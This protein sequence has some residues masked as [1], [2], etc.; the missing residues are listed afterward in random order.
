MLLAIAIV[1]AVVLVIWRASDP[2]E[3]EG[4]QALKEPAAPAPVAASPEIAKPGAPSDGNASVPFTSRRAPDLSGHSVLAGAE[5]LDQGWLDEPSVH[6]RPRYA[7]LIRAREGALLRLVSHHVA[8]SSGGWVA[9]ATDVMRADAVLVAVPRGADATVVARRIQAEGY[10]TGPVQAQEAVVT[11]WVRDVALDA[12]PATID[13]LAAKLPDLLVEPDFVRFGAQVRPDDYDATRLWGLEQ[14]EAPGAWTVTT[15]ASDVV[16]A[17]I[18]S[19][20]TVAH[21]DL[22]PNLWVNPTETPGNGRDDDGNG[23]IDDVHGWNFA[24][25]NATLTDS[26]GHG[27]HVAG[28]IGAVGGNGTGVVGVNWNA[29]I[30]TLRA[31]TDTFL[32]ST[33]LNALRYATA[34]R[35]RGVRVVA[36]NMSLGGTGASLAFRQEIAAARDAGILVVAA[37]GNLSDDLPTADND[38]VA[39]YPASY[40]VD[41]ILAVAST[42]HADALS[43]FSHYGAVSVDLAA[44]GTA[45]F[46]TLTAGGYG[47]SN[48]TSMAAPHVAGAVA[49]VAAAEPSL[50]AAELRDRIVSTVDPVPALAGRVVTGGRLNVRRA[51]APALIRPRVVIGRAGRAVEVAALDRPGLTL[52]LQAMLQADKGVIPT[53]NLAW[54]M[55]DG[56]APVVF[57]STTSADTTALFPGEGRYRLRVTARAGGLQ[58]RDELVV[59]VGADRAVATAGL[60]GWWRFDDAGATTADSSGNGRTGTVTSATRTSTAVFGTA[61]QLDGATSRIGFAAPA[62]SRVTIA[63]WAR[64]TSRNAATIF[65]RIVHMREG[66][67]FG[68]FDTSDTDDGNTDTLKFALDDG[69]SNVVWHTPPG[70][71]VIG[72]WF[73]VAVSYDPTALHAAPVFYLNGVRQI[74]GTQSSSASTPSVGLGVGFIG[75]RGDGAR[76]WLGQLDEIRLYDRALGDAEIAWT[77]REATV[78][79]LAGGVLAAGPT[80][81][82]FVMPLTFTPAATGLG[83][84][85]IEDAAWSDVAGGAIFSDAS[86][87]GATALFTAPGA[88]LV[89]FD[90]LS[91]DGVHVTRT[92]ALE[93]PSTVVA[94]EGYYTG[95]TSTGGPWVLRVRGDGIATFFGA[96]SRGSFQRDF[97]VPEW[98]IF[99]IADRSGAAVTGRIHSDGTVVGTIR[100]AVGALTTFTGA[101]SANAPGPE[102]PARDGIYSGWIIDSG[103]RAAAQVEAGTLAFVVEESGEARA[104]SGAIDSA[105]AFALAAG[106]GSSFTGRAEQGRLDAQVTLPGQPV[107]TAVLFRDGTDAPRRLI[108]LSV[109]GFVG[110]GDAVLIPGFVVDGGPLPVLVRGVGPGL[111]P[112]GVD[113]ALA[114]PRI[115]LRQGSTL[116]QQNTG[117]NLDG[118]TEQIIAA[119]ALTFAF[120]LNP[121]HLDSALT[122]SLGPQAYTVELRG[123]D[124][125][126]GVALA[127][128]YEVPASGS[129]GQLVNISG[130]GFVGTGA[131]VLIGGFVVQGEA[132]AL[133]LV[134]A[135]GPGLERFGVGGV[136]ARPLLRVYRGGA[137]IAAGEAWALADSPATIAAAASSVGAFKFAEDSLDAALLLFLPPGPYTAHVL[138]ADGATGVALLEV[139]R[140]SGM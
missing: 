47:R 120:Q 48:G 75:D 109:R 37:A 116:V 108:N 42:N 50:S 56:P 20:I 107:R 3:S 90:A 63:G 82:P 21:P 6:G 125:G 43:V 111:V 86:A 128:L 8:D 55:E 103:V 32:D 27:T 97:N 115:I 15:G 12:V 140:I 136:L 25:N 101:R 46:S 93:I 106:S 139:Y 4:H 117:W 99:A 10:V 74:T 138:G 69:V 83:A 73:H 40:D 29:R 105:G 113:G 110:T 98:G 34:M 114:Q 126:T 45:I 121:A 89:R 26:G 16:V 81:D 64:A 39:V 94:R 11:V 14:I 71:F 84:P 30:M 17:V 104:A 61:M 19:G 57:S 124:G 24:G 78:Q 13:A 28:T 36:V 102:D 132:P 119:N 130:R 18:D 88:H 67:L 44:P 31:G 54:T 91:S 133:V 95:V 127:E 65:P 112:R 118:Q 5:I 68:G 85:G 41:S 135:T 9:V 92:A 22:A 131:D 7:R 53:A 49:L 72:P 35:L 60:Q 123:A 100:D 1:V 96:S 66:L 77:A 137:I 59:V 2:R 79:A 51:V 58:E 70:S 33:L 76:G 122:R 80:V 52:G 87:S 38:V 62:L 23:F 129:A 134:R